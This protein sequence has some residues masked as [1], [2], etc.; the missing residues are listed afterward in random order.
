MVVYVRQGWSQGEALKQAV[1]E[2]R[3][4]WRSSPTGGSVVEDD[5]QTGQPGSKRPRNEGHKKKFA[6]HFKGQQICRAFN[7][8]SNC[9]SKG[10]GKGCPRGELHVCDVVLP[11]G[12]VCG[13]KGHNRSGHRA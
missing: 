4:D 1:I 2:H 10:K 9:K 11:S 5:L 13:N 6:Q 8:G 12:K 7:D 3:V